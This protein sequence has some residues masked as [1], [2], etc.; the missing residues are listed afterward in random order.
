MVERTV[1][2]S[3]AAGGAKTAYIEPDSSWE[4]GYIESFNA[5]ELLNGEIFYALREAQ[6]VIESWRCHYNAVRPHLA[7]LQTTS[8]EG[9]CAR[10][11]RVAGFASRPASRATL[12]QPPALN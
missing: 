7:R 3:I 12:A 6:I 1:Q 10:I 2:E 4:N 11:R 9:F 5:R 8:T